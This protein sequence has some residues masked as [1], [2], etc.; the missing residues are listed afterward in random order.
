MPG[1]TALV[2]AALAAAGPAVI[3]DGHVD[4]GPRFAD[5]RWTI[6]MRDDTGPR[7]VWRDLSGTVLHAV[8]AARLRV[9]AGF[10]FLGRPGARAWVVP[11]VQRRGVVWP[12][13]NT[14][15]REVARKVV[16]EVTWRLHGVRGP[17]RFVL[18]LTDA[19]GAPR[20]LFDSARPYPQQIGID[21][22]T[23]VHGNWAFTA[24]GA[25]ELDIEMRA[26]TRE[27]ERVSDRGA[28]R[29]AVG[30][31]DPAAAFEERDGSTPAAV[32]IVPGAAAL[33]GL[34][35]IVLVRRRR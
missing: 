34:G 27:G 9:P 5:G 28:L 22:D 31:G 7:P 20:T 29:F 8:D 33:A 10:P 12:G 2:A 35:G 16:R 26:R 1:L 19:F 23:H 11:Q 13:W 32:W 18:F 21:V 17:G 14:Q 30:A 6:Q 4:V 15:D 24:P 25:Y 3:A